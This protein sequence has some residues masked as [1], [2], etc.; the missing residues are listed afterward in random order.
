MECSMPARRGTQ[1]CWRGPKPFNIRMDDRPR[2][3]RL[4]VPARLT[5]CRNR[6]AR[7]HC[8]VG[9]RDLQCEI[10]GGEP[11]DLPNPFTWPPPLPNGCPV[12]TGALFMFDNKADY[13]LFKL[14][15]EEKPGWVHGGTW[16]GEDPSTWKMA[17][18]DTWEEPKKEAANWRSLFHTNRRARQRAPNYLRDSRFFTRGRHYDARC[19]AQSQQN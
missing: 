15:A 17:D 6:L 19:S 5:L 3:P 12:S 16:D 9:G 11:D 8:C 10:T 4:Q 2:L 14:Q 7:V 18:F 1:Q 13:A